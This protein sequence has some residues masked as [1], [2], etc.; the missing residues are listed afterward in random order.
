MSALESSSRKPPAPTIRTGGALTVKPYPL[1]A[2]QW[3]GWHCD[4][5]P[6]GSWQVAGDELQ[7]VRAGR[8]KLHL[9]HEYLTVNGPPGEDG[10]PGTA[11]VHRTLLTVNGRPPRPGDEPGCL[12]PK[13]ISPEPLGSGS[14]SASSRCSRR[15]RG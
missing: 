11:D 1:N 2:D 9:P 14:G 10:K 4:A 13:G 5:F 3:R 12:D 8:W 7:A 6:Q 15:Q